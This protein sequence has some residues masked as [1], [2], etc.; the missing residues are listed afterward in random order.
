VTPLIEFTL[1]RDRNGYN[2]KIL[3][4]T[5]TTKGVGWSSTL[6]IKSSLSSNWS[7]VNCFMYPVAVEGDGADVGE[8]TNEY[9]LP[10]PPRPPKPVDPQANSKFQHPN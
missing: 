10:P 7:S 8:E 3:G 9:P 4:D 6:G 1:A 2:T 5:I